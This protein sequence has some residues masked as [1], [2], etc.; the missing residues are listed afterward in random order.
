MDEVKG[1]I[2]LGTNGSAAAR[3]AADWAARR[4]AD[5]G[6]E[7]VLVHVVPAR[8]VFRLGDSYEAARK[9]G[10]DLLDGEVA[11]LSGPDA[12]LKVTGILADGEPAQALRALSEEAELVVVGTDRGPDAHGEGFGSVSFQTSIISHSP[13]TVVPVQGQRPAAGVVVGVDGSLE[14]RIAAEHAAAEAIRLGEELTMVHAATD[15]SAGREILGAARDGVAAANPGL[16]VHELLDLD[17]GPADALL[18]ASTSARLLVLG[19]RGKGGLRVLIGSVAKDVLFRIHCPTLVT[20][21][22]RTMAGLPTVS[23]RGEAP[24][25]R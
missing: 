21:P 13:V 19:C 24:S 23:G 6:D 12:R 4:A 2:L 16:P 11:R 14:S 9:L 8:T 22:A 3:A 10:Q 7:L 1:R 20:R 17:H 15:T 18:K 25:E 5:A